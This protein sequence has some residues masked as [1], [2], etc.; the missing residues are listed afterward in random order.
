M[1]L[2]INKKAAIFKMMAEKPAYQV[3]LAFEL[4]KHYKNAATV[5]SAVIRIFH[6]VKHNPEKFMIPLDTVDVI[7]HAVASRSI[8]TRSKE[9]RI[10][11]REQM[12]IEKNKPLEEIVKQNSQ[13]SA[14][15]LS[16]RI[17]DALQ[18]KKA[19]QKIGI[20]EL[21]KVYGITFDKRAL[22][23][24]RATEHVAVLGKL[25]TEAMT[26]AEA[27]EVV[28]KMREYNQAVAEETTKRK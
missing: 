17:D 18:S 19:R 28:L 11:L 27:I 7:A 20:G 22:V 5:A 26:P 21:A 15:L 6:E 10:S 3:G 25:A 16:L 8:G 12:D 9:N 24:G 23:E 1:V 14:V 2:D 13:K 4:D